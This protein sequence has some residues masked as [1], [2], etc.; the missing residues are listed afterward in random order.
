LKTY[1]ENHEL[2]V[3]GN[4]DHHISMP[5]NTIMQC[6][7]IVTKAIERGNMRDQRK[8]KIG[9]LAISTYASVLM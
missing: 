5:I 6:V 4:A 7:K 3:D 2:E 8:L 1:L 9:T